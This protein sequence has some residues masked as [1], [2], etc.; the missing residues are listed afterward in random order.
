MDIAEPLLEQR[1]KL[2]EDLGVFYE[3]SE[4]LPPLSARIFASLVLAGYQGVCFKT[5]TQT[6]CASK[7]SISANLQ[8]LQTAGIV[9][10]ETVTG[11]RKR[12]FKIGADEWSNRIGHKLD[13]WKKEKELHDKVSCY[14]KKLLEADPTNPDAQKAVSITEQYRELLQ[15]MITNLENIKQQID[16]N[17]NQDQ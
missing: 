4:N 10:Y 17:S 16:T 5:L 9:S 11:D 2:V 6:L 13:N 3:T 7:S 8:L 1:K 14:K 12:Y 15:Y